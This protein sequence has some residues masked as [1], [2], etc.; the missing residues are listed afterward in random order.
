[1]VTSP[2]KTHAPFVLQD[3]I[4]PKSSAVWPAVMMAICNNQQ[5]APTHPTQLRVITVRLDQAAQVKC[6]R[7]LAK[8]QD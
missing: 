1:M 6:L 8:R 4:T 7:H 5:Q 2:G 3:R